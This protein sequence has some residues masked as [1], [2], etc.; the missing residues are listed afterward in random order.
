MVSDA[1][2]TVSL[3]DALTWSASSA[4]CRPHFGADSESDSNGS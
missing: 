2:G 3:I 4:T 1:L